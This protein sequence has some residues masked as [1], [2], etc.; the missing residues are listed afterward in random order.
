MHLTSNPIFYIKTT[1]TC[2]L[3]CKHC[4][5][6]GSL[7]KKIF[8]NPQK[9]I[10]FFRRLLVSNPQ[11]RQAKFLLH[12]GEPLLAKISLIEEFCDEIIK[13]YPQ[14][15]FAMQ[16]NLVFP[17]TAEKRQFMQ[18]YLYNS[19]FGTSWDYDIRFGSTSNHPENFEQ[20]KNFQL[21]TWEQNVKTLIGEDNHFMTMIVS[22]TKKLIQEK[23]PIEILQYA[24]SLGFQNILFER[25]TSD[26]NAKLNSDIIPS[27]E[28]QDTWLYKMFKQ[29]FEYKSYKYIFNMF[30][31][32]IAQGYLNHG[33]VG[34]RCRNCE[35]KIL[36]I[37][38]DGSIGG[39]PNTA[40]TGYWGHIDWPVSESLTSA[41]RLDT[42]A[43]ERFERNVL[44]YTCDALPYCNSD[45]HQLAW[46]QD[47][48]YC[49]APKKIWKEMMQE[50][51]VEKYKL[52]LA[53]EPV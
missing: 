18:K 25:I 44:C 3:N 19:G 4:F 41:K 38:A 23:E 51:N 9:T 34:N 21:K 7:G 49:P 27:N 11:I 40:P 24:K 37:N 16:T 17:L 10:D 43:C 31:S 47:N 1:E 30:L 39:C 45:C 48:S 29:T 46:D 22:I 20:L 42:I 15:S 53:H 12:G 32:E 13:L 8:F 36:T 26:G 28:E 33:H 14:S 6:S 5:T 2:N 35:Q 52:L 50:N